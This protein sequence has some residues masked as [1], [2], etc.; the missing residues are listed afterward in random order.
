MTDK[1]LAYLPSIGRLLGFAE[2]RCSALSERELAPHG[3]TLTHWVILTALWRDDGLTIG[4]L[5][6]YARSTNAVLTRTLDR[7]TDRGLVIRQAD[8]RD[9][10]VIRVVLTP[11]ARS[12]AHLIDFY[13]QI[14]QVLLDGFSRKEQ[15]T[16]VALLERVIANTEAALAG[17]KD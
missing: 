12:L 17:N 1:N 8:S 4:E 15:Q 14:N 11:K 16:L 9:R 10:R 3:L 5:A 7:M 6:R 2:R 13:K